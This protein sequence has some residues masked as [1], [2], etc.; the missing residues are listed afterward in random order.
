M[1]DRHDLLPL[2]YRLG[3]RGDDGSIDC[4]GVTLRGAMQVHGC[5]PDPWRAIAR[6]W[7]RG[8]LATSSGFPSCWIRQADASPIAHGAVLLFFGAHPWA[9]IVVDGH[10]WSADADLGVYCRPLVRWEKR[11]AEVWQ[12]DPAAH[13]ARP[14][15]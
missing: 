6:A 8:E 13:S 1:P 2:R 14:D 12:H 10:V 9:A 7:A 4:L 5:A 11:P 3:G 15:R